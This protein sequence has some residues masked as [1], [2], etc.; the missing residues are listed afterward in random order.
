MKMTAIFSSLFMGLTLPSYAFAHISLPS[1]LSG[2]NSQNLDP[3]E[4]IELSQNYIIARNISQSLYNSQSY[5]LGIAGQYSGSDAR[6]DYISV[7]SVNSQQIKLNIH[8]KIMI[9]R[10]PPIRIGLYL[11][12]DGR[13][14]YQVV[15]YD[16]ATGR[17]CRSLCDRKV[18][19]KLRNL[20][21]KYPD[22]NNILRRII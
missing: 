21:S 19:D 13:G 1:N 16:W 17:R 15:N 9:R 6:W 11:Q 3:L 20:P 14:N 12:S 7:E 2:V 22:F 18:R 8:G 10:K 5:I 4:T